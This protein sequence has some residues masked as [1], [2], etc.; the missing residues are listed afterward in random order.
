V[1]SLDDLHELKSHEHAGIE[2]VICGRALYDGR[3]DPADAL[4]VLAGDAGSTTGSG[5]S[6]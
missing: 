6:A 5:G 2:G 3:I 4:A 1:S